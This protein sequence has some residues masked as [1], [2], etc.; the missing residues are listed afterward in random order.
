MTDLH[1]KRA[2]AL[3]QATTALLRGSIT[4]LTAI[5]L[6]LDSATTLKHR[7]K[8]VDRLL[9]ADCIWHV[10]R[11]IEALHSVGCKDCRNC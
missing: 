7:I 4:S 1:V 3:L 11:Y 9:G 5:A 10:E 2:A 8:S 6:C